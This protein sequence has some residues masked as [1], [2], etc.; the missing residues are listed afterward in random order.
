MTT[1]LYGSKRFGVAYSACWPR[2]S[3]SPSRKLVVGLFKGSSSPVVP[4][5]QVFIDRVPK[6][7]KEWAIDSSGR[8]TRSALLISAH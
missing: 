2:A 3:G 8:T 7:L 6:P 5:G 4:V 1:A